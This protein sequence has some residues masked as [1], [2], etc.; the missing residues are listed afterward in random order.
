MNSQTSLPDG[1][2]TEDRPVRASEPTVLRRV[3][4]CRG[5]LRLRPTFGRQ[6]LDLLIGGEGQAREDIAQ[7]GVRVETAAPATLD[8]RVDD[9]AAIAGFRFAD[10]E[11]VLFA[12][13]RRTN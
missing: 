4:E 6:F 13:S 11:P 9:R 12:N 2:A 1:G 10:E 5:A 3:A 8:H 7:I